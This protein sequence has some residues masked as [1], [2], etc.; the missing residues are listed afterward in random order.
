MSKENIY[1]GFKPRQDRCLVQ[2]DKA[3]Q[4]TP[5]GILIPGLENAEL[6]QGI[7]MAI[8]PKVTDLKVGA[9]VKYGQH[10]GFQVEHLGN[11]FRLIRAD[12]AYCE[13]EG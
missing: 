5:G 1:K 4:V 13:I 3:Q 11:E 7:V 12:D 8:G 6:F 9:K 10:S 2:P